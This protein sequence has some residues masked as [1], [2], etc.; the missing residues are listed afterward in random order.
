MKKSAFKLEFVPIK[1]TNINHY[2]LR[3]DEDD[4]IRKHGMSESLSGGPNPAVEVVVVEVAE[5]ILQLMF[6]LIARR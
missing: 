6:T 3:L 2:V 5:E 4:R 1:G